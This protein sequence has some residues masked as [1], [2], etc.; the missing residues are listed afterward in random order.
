MNTLTSRAVVG[1]LLVLGL[2]VWL[3]SSLSRAANMEVSG[4][5]SVSGN[6][7]VGQQD[8]A[9]VYLTQPGA[10]PMEFTYG[11]TGTYQ[12]SV[13]YHNQMNGFWI[14]VARKGIDASYPSYDFTIARRGEST[15]RFA[16]KG[17]TFGHVAIGAAPNNTAKLFV[18][19]ALVGCYAAQ[20]RN[21]A[22]GLSA[23]GLLIESGPNT[24]EATE[25]MAVRFLTGNGSYEVGKIVWD[26]NSIDLTWVSDARLK[27]N[28][29]E[30]LT[31]SLA[32][33]RNTRV[34][35]YE[36]I[37]LPG[38]QYTGF[39]AQ[40]LAV[41]FPQAVFSDTD[42]ST[43]LQT[44]SIKPMQLIPHIFHAIQQQDAGVG[45]LQ[46]TSEVHGARLTALEESRAGLAQ[47]VQ[48]LATGVIRVEDLK[49]GAEN[50]TAVLEM[51]AAVLR[52]L[53][54]DPW[55]EIALSDAIETAPET[56]ESSVTKAV[57][58]YRLNLETAQAEA[59]TVEETVTEQ[60]PTGKT[61]K[62]V[63]SGVR[64]DEATGKAYRWVGLSSAGAAE[65][66]TALRTANQLA[67]LRTANQLAALQARFVAPPL[68]GPEFVAPSSGGQK[69]VA[70]P[71]GGPEFV[72]PPS[73]GQELVA[74]PSGGVLS[75]SASAAAPAN[76]KPAAR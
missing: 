30:C 57:T 43:G 26:S 33:I 2:P 9:G 24:P 40:E 44:L 53:G 59:Y 61:V 39:I 74:P 15:P 35:T 64:F 60:T 3:E 27:M 55:V 58:K 28:I 75:A 68:G 32:K 11:G 76:S 22:N 67:T 36:R 71:L 54:V 20:F 42:S 4:T 14:D 16:I 37:H 8:S 48:D 23:R 17:D 19:Q 69:L 46:Q 73:G 18:S 21:N 13:I 45:A 12:K 63:K 7:T 65:T 29:Q 70:P 38:V 1:L 5:Q 62:R 31:D 56:V 72:A 47:Q 41:E 10:Y 49:P 6:L 34:A 51:A 25:H 52:Q 50:T 66:L